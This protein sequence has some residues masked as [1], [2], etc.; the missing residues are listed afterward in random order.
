M[1][2]R[3]KLEAERTKSIDRAGLSTA[4]MPTICA[5]EATPES[6]P[7]WRLEWYHPC[8]NTRCDEPRCRICS[9]SKH[10]CCG[11]VVQPPPVIPYGTLT[12][13]SHPTTHHPFQG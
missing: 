12:V 11:G 10:R 5:E 1:D 13:T 7:T 4:G 9:C 6:K 2:A 8:T 3:I